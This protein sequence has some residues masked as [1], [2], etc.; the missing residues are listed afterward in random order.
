M[1]RAS[2]RY[3]WESELRKNYL[4]VQD[5]KIK[6]TVAIKIRAV[7]GDSYPATVRWISKNRN[8]GSSPIADLVVLLVGRYDRKNATKAQ[9]VEE[10]VAM[11]IKVVFAADL[12]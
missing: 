11:G 5:G 4:S 3:P 1:M 12:A 10:L 6:S 9:F 8:H 2:I 7:I